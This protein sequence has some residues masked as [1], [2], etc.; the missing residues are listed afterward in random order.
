MGIGIQIN[1]VAV[2]VKLGTAEP[3]VLS[4]VHKLEHD[5]TECV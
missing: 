5:G 2:E 4:R 3:E 1:S